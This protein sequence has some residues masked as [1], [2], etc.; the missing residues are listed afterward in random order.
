[1]TTETRLD[2][3]LERLAALYATDAELQ[4]ARPSPAV[5]E[6]ARRPGNRL[7]EILRIYAESYADR[8]ALGTRATSTSRGERRLQP[9]FDTITYGQLWSNVTAV[10]AAWTADDAVDPGDFVATIGFASADYLTVDLVSN[11]LGLVAVP[12]QHNSPASRLRPIFAETVP[13]VLAVSADYLDLAV[14]CALTT[15]SVRR[16]TVFDYDAEIDSQ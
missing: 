5:V 6:A 3:R 4:T 10:A 1:M 9:E 2:T 7:A 15:P 14:Q 8:P 12:L 16:L 13:R 11:Y